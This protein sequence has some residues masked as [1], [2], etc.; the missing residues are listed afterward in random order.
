MYF[1]PFNRIFIVLLAFTASLSVLSAQ[2]VSELELQR[3]Q[4]LK[5]LEATSKML[6][7][8]KKSKSNSLIKLSLINKNIKERKTLISNINGEIGVLNHEITKL[9]HEKTAL[10][11]SLKSLKQDYAKLIQD[12]SINRG[13]YNKFMF[14]LSAQSFD[15]SMRRFRYMKEYSDYREKQ[16]HDIEKVTTQIGLKN[17]SLEGH[18][19]T[20]VE[21]VKAKVTETQNLTKDEQRE[22]ILLTDLQ[23]EEQKL[24]A[25]LREQQKRA[26]DLNNKIESI[27]AAEIRKAEAKKAAERSRL[28]A[29]NNARLAARQK[30]DTKNGV[31]AKTE[32]TTVVK[33]APSAIP[34]ST[35]TR[36]ETLLSG[37]FERNAGRLPWP[38]SNGFISGHYGVQPHPMLR[39]VT[40]NNKGVYIQTPANSTARAVF[41]GVVTQRFSIPGSNNAVIIKH[42]N[43]RTVYANLTQIFVGE[44]DRVS[45]KQA[46]GKIYTDDEADNKTELYFQVWKDKN[47][48]NPEKWITK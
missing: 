13:V 27:I 44:G 1:N 30:A 16:V 41:E 21:V 31:K 37:N 4:T 48:Q 8:T 33:E 29:E 40:T 47:L 43:F 46:I 24:R 38:V 18:K 12:G 45:A 34:V 28:E 39:H 11:N 7:A 15:Q 9:D 20:K 6:S 17:D 3:K 2:S 14:V 32:S 10:E 35:L 19:S 25:E 26:N 42:G 23:R 22:K 36:E 5:R